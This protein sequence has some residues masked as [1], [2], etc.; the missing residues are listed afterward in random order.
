VVN[1]YFDR[2]KDTG[3]FKLFINEKEIPSSSL[4]LWNGIATL[5]FPIL[6]Y[7]IN[8]ILKFKSIISDN[9]NLANPFVEEFFVRIESE[10]KFNGGNGKR[11]PPASEKNGQKNVNQE[12]LALPNI[13]QIRKEEW[14][15]YSFDKES[16]LK[17]KGNNEDGYDFFINLDN[18]HLLTELK[19]SKQEDMKILEARY[20][21]GMVLIGLA[22]L[23]DSENNSNEVGDDIY[24]QIFKITKRISPIL[25]PMI[26]SLGSLEIEETEIIE[27]E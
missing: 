20:Q 13:I 18:I 5:N 27:S 3:L 17:V 19:L 16:A 4:N 6:G 24:A 9:H 10:Q 14:E 21:Y 22:L 25:I 1:D 7:S 2:S 11:I 23:N 12:G 26:G 8:Q 15:I